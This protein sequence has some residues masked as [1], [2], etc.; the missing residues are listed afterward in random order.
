MLHQKNVYKILIKSLKKIKHKNKYIL[1][2][3][4]T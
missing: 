4:N 3:K 1:Y 2:I